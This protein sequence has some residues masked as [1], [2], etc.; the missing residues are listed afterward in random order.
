VF[1]IDLL[2]AFI[3]ALL[4]SAIFFSGFRRQ[5]FG[6]GLFI[7][8]LVLFLA[9]WAGGVW[10]TPVGPLLWGASWLS[11][12]VVGFFIALLLSLLIPSGKSYSRSTEE[13]VGTLIALDTLFWGF[14]IVFGIGILISYL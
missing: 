11:F 10:V 6:T 14:I 2:F 1:I 8:F 13:E 7:L 9:T 4:F 3:I 5:G 12:V